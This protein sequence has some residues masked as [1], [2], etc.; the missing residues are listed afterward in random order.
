MVTGCV[1]GHDTLTKV[2]HSQGAAQK[3]FILWHV[4]DSAD[5]SAEEMF[6]VD[7]VDVRCINLRESTKFH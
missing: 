7:V 2:R 1:F 4:F 5:H 6:P 3:R